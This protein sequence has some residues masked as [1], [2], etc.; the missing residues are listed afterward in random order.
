MKKGLT[1][2]LAT[3]VMAIYSLSAMAMAP[4]ILDI[5]D[6]IIG[7][8]EDTSEANIFVYP[9]GL[10]LSRNN[11]FTDVDTPND[12]DIE[13]S[14]YDATGKYVMNGIGSLDLSPTGDD[15]VNPSATGKAI[16][17][18]DTADP[19][20]DSDPFTVTARNDSLSPL[21]G[22]P[23]YAEPSTTGIL[24]GETATLTFFVSDGAATDSATVSVY[25]DNE[26]WDSPSPVGEIPYTLV[27]TVDLIAG[28]AGWT[29]FNVAAITSSTSGGLCMTAPLTGEA[30]ATWS[31]P[32]GGS[33]GLELVNNQVYQVRLTM[34]STASSGETAP[35]WDIIFEN[36]SSDGSQGAFAYSADMWFLGKNIGSNG[37]GIDRTEFLI[38]Y[39]PSCVNLTTWQSE[40]F[41]TANDA[42][43]DMR[44][45]FRVL[46]SDAA[47]Y[48]ANIDVGTVCLVGYTV[49]RTDVSNL[50]DIS[51]AY[52]KTTMAEADWTVYPLVGDGS[53]TSIVWADGDLTV[54]PTDQTTQGW[55]DQLINIDAGNFGGGAFEINEISYP[56]VW[57]DESLYKLE[58]T[59]S[60][61]DSTGVNN[62]PDWLDLQLDAANNELFGESFVLA[63]LDRIAMPK[64]TS[65]TYVSFFYGHELPGTSV[66]A[67]FKRLRGHLNWGARTDI[68]P[69]SVTTNFGGIK[70]HSVVVRKVTH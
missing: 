43:N 45:T 58:V 53:D 44:M 48:G 34:S 12:A 8:A 29:F 6:I 52:A 46:D 47:G 9:D 67:N 20:D 35:L 63:N 11:G 27:T 5:S 22:T 40:A 39:A 70:I 49:K 18:S 21:S 61:P 3:V 66:D 51:T 56:I 42:N 55:G 38:Y 33:G 69:N 2:T 19:G 14:F 64:L 16:N 13:W 28:T 26:G 62:P 50:E 31:S 25:C 10:N 36:Q 65:E 17:L 54:T 32:Y 41:T 68:S 57:E 15:V 30:M 24:A 23:P 37:V 60:A 4:T 59:M 1:L 7:D